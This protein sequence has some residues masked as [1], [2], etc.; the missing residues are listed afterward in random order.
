MA[1]KAFT[2]GFFKTSNNTLKHQGNKLSYIG[3]QFEVYEDKHIVK[4]TELKNSEQDWLDF[5]K[6]IYQS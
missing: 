6:E 4:C 1:I 3:G 2:C 5:L